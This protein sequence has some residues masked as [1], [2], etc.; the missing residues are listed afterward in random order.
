MFTG[1]AG[2]SGFQ[3]FSHSLWCSFPHRRPPAFRCRV[4][5]FAGLSIFHFSFSHSVIPRQHATVQYFHLS[6]SLR[7]ISRDLCFPFVFS[8]KFSSLRFFC[9]PA[10]VSFVCIK[11]TNRPLKF[12]RVI[13]GLH[14]AVFIGQPASL[15]SFCLGNNFKFRLS[16]KISRELCFLVVSVHGC[17]VIWAFV[18][19]RPAHRRCNCQATSGRHTHF[20][21]AYNLSFSWDMPI[22]LMLASLIIAVSKNHAAAIKELFVKTPV[23]NR[24]RMQRHRI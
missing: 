10:E 1:L 15:P 2:L 22:F 7:R 21:G 5:A 23:S 4:H 8:S 13:L 19:V 3:P 20:S 16:V 17:N 18:H 11:F 9:A 24:A 6:H 14:N 12:E